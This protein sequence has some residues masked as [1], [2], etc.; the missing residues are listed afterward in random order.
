MRDVVREDNIG[1]AKRIY[2]LDGNNFKLVV[3]L[4]LL[5]FPIFLRR[6][7]RKI[8]ERTIFLFNTDLRDVQITVQ[9]PTSL[10]NKYVCIL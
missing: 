2:A 1:I 7:D 5:S 9:L 10:K 8:G 3:C 6:A 4:T